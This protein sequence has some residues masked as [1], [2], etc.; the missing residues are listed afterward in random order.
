VTGLDLPSSALD[1]LLAVDR[2]AWAHECDLVQDWFTRFG[3]ALPPAV[4]AQL[5]RLRNRLSSP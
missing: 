5:T 1:E 3:P 2:E 4:D